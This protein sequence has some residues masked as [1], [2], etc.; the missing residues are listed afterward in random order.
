MA[1]RKL[2]RLVI[3][4]ILQESTWGTTADWPVQVESARAQIPPRAVGVVW[5]EAGRLGW[6]VPNRTGV[7]AGIGPQVREADRVG[8]VDLLRTR[9][10]SIEARW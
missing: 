2:I 3:E 1:R 8:V 10:G 5:H 7:A 9:T 6:A 4:K